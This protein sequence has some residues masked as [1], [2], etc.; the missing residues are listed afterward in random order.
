[1]SV[2]EGN[3]PRYGIPETR[4]FANLLAGYATTER[5]E[6][7]FNFPADPDPGGVGE[8]STTERSVSN[9]DSPVLIEV[10]GFDGPLL[11]RLEA[12]TREVLSLAAQPKPL[13]LK[14]LEAR[15]GFEPTYRG[16]ADLE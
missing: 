1:L 4:E 14:S 9:S 6:D 3:C 8:R 11:V 15:V 5:Q 2:R 10:I 13:L 16:F 7:V 12:R